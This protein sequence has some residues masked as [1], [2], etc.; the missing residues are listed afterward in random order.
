MAFLITGLVIGIA[1]IVGL[2]S[3]TTAMK[4]EIADKFDEIGANMTVVPKSDD[5]SLSYGGV[6][7]SDISFDVK[8]LEMSAIEKIKSIKNKENIAI[9]APKLMGTI[10]AAEQDL[11]VVGVDFTSELRM[12]KWWKLQG[13]RP[14]DKR[15]LIL[16]SELAKSLNK[17]PGDSLQIEGED[18]RVS[19]IIEATGG[20]DDNAMFMGL[21]ETQRILDKPGVISFIEVA[22]L[23]S[24]CPIEEIVM[25]ISNE[26]PTAKVTA[27]KEVV[28]ARKDVV[29]RFAGMAMA[30]S[31]IV[32]LIG[33]LVVLVTMMSSV[34]ER[35]R[36]IGIFRAIGFRKSHVI[37][38]ILLE[39]IIVSI[40]GGVI[41]Y[42]V[43]ISLAKVFAPIIAQMDVLI[44]WKPEVAVGA[45]V[46][47]ILVGLLASAFPAFK[48]AGKDPVES[49]RFI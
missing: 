4:G 47:S 30:V 14:E 6:S 27:V 22:A 35:T 2:Y 31:L 44:E 11:L 16:G 3:I 32:L 13:S 24:T 8:E 23:C 10:Q 19:A 29:E 41:G 48:A 36:E 42:L 9:V 33:A 28:Q 17:K 21:A 37:N 26:I 45:L 15:D 40:I 5:L 18:F 43:G 49:L 12:K 25:Q 34:N 38:I 39:A 7:V 46:I 20:Q 1:T